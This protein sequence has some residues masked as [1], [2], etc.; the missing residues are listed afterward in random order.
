MTQASAIQ[1]QNPREKIWG[2][3]VHQELPLTDFAESL[4]IQ[5]MCADFMQKHHIPIDANDALLPGYGPHLDYMWE[6]RVESLKQQALEKMG[7]AISYMAINRFGLSGY[8]HPLM[9]N[10]CLSDEEIMLAE[11]NENQPNAIWFTYKVP[12]YQEFFFNP[13]RDS[14]N[15]IMDT[16]TSRIMLAA[17]IHHLKAVGRNNLKNLPF[18]DPK[19]EII[20]GFHIHMD[21]EPEQEILALAIFDNFLRYLLSEDMHPTSTRIYEANDNG[22]HLLAGWEVKFET[23]DS[24]ILERIGIAIGWLMCNRQNLSVF[25]HPVTWEEGDYAEELKAHKEYSFFLGTL[26]DLDLTFFSNKM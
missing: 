22:P 23:R 20:R 17:D 18:R 8:I 21:Y 24:R 15:K 25:M 4:V 1:W 9:Q 6:L 19:D 10:I 11:G 16:R 5:E 3:H 26:P 12:Q 13:P 14:H 7:L 2:F